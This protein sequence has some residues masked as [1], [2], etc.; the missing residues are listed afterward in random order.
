LTLG[1]KIASFFCYFKTTQSISPQMESST[2][3]G[4]LELGL[5]LW[6]F[7][8]SRRSVVIKHKGKETLKDTLFLS[9]LLDE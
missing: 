4:E 9:I 7:Y 3:D 6:E 8:S 5:L 1:L 2:P